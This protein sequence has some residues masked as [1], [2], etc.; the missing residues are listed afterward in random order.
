MKEDALVAA[1]STCPSSRASEET[2]APSTPSC[3][4]PSSQRLSFMGY[5]QLVSE[6][7]LQPSRS[8]PSYPYPSHSKKVSVFQPLFPRNIADRRARTALSQGNSSEQY[9]VSL[10]LPGRGGGHGIFL[11]GLPPLL[12]T[13]ALEG[14]PRAPLATV[15]HHQLWVLRP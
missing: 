15:G 10:K 4:S 2:R 13:V 8:L 3:S 14:Q 1:A 6:I 11:G 12:Y 9:H 7:Y 5:E